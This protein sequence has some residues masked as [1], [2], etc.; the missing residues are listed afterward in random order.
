MVVGD[1][2]GGNANILPKIKKA[3]EAGIT[4]VLV[5]GDAGLWTH[6]FDGHVFLDAIQRT[7][8]DNNLS[9]FFIGGNHENWDHWNWFV[10][11]MPKS[12]GWAYVRSRVLL[13]PKAHKW[14]WAGKQFVA[15]GGAVSIDKE[16]RLLQEK[17]DPYMDATGRTRS[18]KPPQPRTLYW[19]NEQL[20]DE[21]VDVIRKWN[22]KAD[23]L[24]THDCS[25]KTPFRG[26]LKPDID[27]QIHRQRIDKVLMLTTPEIHFHGHMHTKYDWMNFV[28]ERN[29]EA[30]YVQTYGLECNSD[31]NSWGTLDV[32]TGRFVWHNTVFREK[33]EF[34]FNKD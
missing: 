11:N 15:A 26:R 12:K 4:H 2:H 17:G 27:S 21:D 1:T 7:A 3:G 28:G 34:G 19:D 30:V 18:R 22:V 8:E 20:T 14:S 32:E 5:V 10:D 6:Y 25:N 16:A 9:V 23:Y 29:G 24:F 33:D 13:A 31:F